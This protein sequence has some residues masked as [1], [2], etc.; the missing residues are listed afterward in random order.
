M[1]EN[2]DLLQG[3]DDVQDVQVKAA[4]EQVEEGLTQVTSIAEEE[5]RTGQKINI[6]NPQELVARASSS[7]IANQQHLNGLINRRNGGTKFA[8]SRQGMNRVMNAIFSLPTDGIKVSLQNDAE[9]VA[10]AIGQNIVRDMFVIMANHAFTEAK[11]AKE[12]S[13]QQEQNNDNI[14]EEKQEGGQ[15]D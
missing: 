2:K 3:S 8:I 6:P 11:K 13:L 5:K 9:K 7:L 12:S 15:N 10:F 1:E 14:K 4:Q